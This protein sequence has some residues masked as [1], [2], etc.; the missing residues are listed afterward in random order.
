MANITIDGIA[1]GVGGGT[2]VLEAALAQGI[3][4][5]TFCYQKR[6]SPLASC[7]MCLVAI[8]GWPKLQPA[9]VTPVPTRS[10]HHPD[11][12]LGARLGISA[13]SGR[14]L[15]HRGRAHCRL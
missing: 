14:K 8:E 6:L 5:P 15:L 2:L 13:T 1:L 9:C 7:R 4:V 12:G 11:R 10:A 3:D